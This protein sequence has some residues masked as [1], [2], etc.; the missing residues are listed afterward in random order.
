MTSPVT[1]SLTSPIASSLTSLRTPSVTFLEKAKASFAQL[2]EIIFANLTSNEVASLDFWAEDTDFIRLSQ[3]RVRQNTSVHQASLELLLQSNFANLDPNDQQNGGGKKS[4]RF[5]WTL[6]LESSHDISQSLLNLGRAR[7]EMSQLP[8]DPFAVEIQN[9]GESSQD[10]DGD[11]P[12]SSELVGRVIL[13]AQGCDLVGLLCSGR[14]ISAV[15]NSLGQR[16]WFSSRSFFIDYS[17]YQGKKSVKGCYADQNWSDEL[18]QKSFDAAKDQLTIVSQSPQPL[19]PGRYRAYIA[20]AAVSEILSHLNWG[21]F[22]QQC[23]RRGSS[24]FTQLL[25]NQVRLSPLLHLRENFEL[26]LTP[27]FNAFGEVSA[28]HLDLLENGKLIQLLT[29]SKSAREFGVSANGAN[30]YECL[31][32]PEI[33]PGALKR[34]EILAKLDTGL[35]ISNL[36]YLAWSDHLTA[37]MTGMTRFGCFWVENGRIV[38][39][40]A[41]LRFDDSLY[42][43]WG[44]GLEAITDFQEID[45]EIGTYFNR[46]MGGRKVP[47][48]LLSSLKFT[49]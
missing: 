37:R 28:K 22:S 24:P 44:D 26:G 46:S 40:I 23:Y 14:V 10:Q 7:K 39:P 11:F 29:H 31:R 25:N 18:W 5:R 42:R 2:S 15:S 19:A 36:H 13:S 35:Y 16:H 20:P 38:G 4:A 30:E 48:M 3:N 1:S 9:H 8:P 45:P 6:T 43:F 41:D 47:G 21:A 34:S 32:S 49:L 33:L 27:R 17:L 12:D